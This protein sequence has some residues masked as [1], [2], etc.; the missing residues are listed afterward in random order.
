MEI[1]AQPT[2]GHCLLVHRFEYFAIIG[3]TVASIAIWIAVS[4]FQQ[5]RESEAI[6]AVHAANVGLAHTLG[7]Q[8]IQVLH[9]T[10]LQTAFLAEDVVRDG[11]R[12]VNTAKYFDRIHADLPYIRRISILDAGGNIISSSA[13]FH[14][15]SRANKKYFA[16]HR[17]D[18]TKAVFIGKPMPDRTL[19]AWQIPI[20]RR[21]NDA[22]GRFVGVVI[23]A[24]DPAYFSKQFTKAALG[25]TSRLS[26]IDADGIVLASANSQGMEIGSDVSRMPGYKFGQANA[27][28]FFIGEGNSIGA[29][30]IVAYDQLSPYSMTLHVATSLDEA[31]A[32]VHHEVTAVYLIATVITLLL[33]A[34]SFTIARQ[35]DGQ[36]RATREASAA[37]ER[38][39]RLLDENRSL[40]ANLE[41]RV[42]ERTAELEAANRELNSFSYTIAHDLRAPVRAMGGYSSLVLEKS[43]ALLDATA[44]QYL[45]RVVAGSKRMGQLIDDLLNMARLSRQE[46][47]RTDIDLTELAGAVAGALEAA[48]PQREVEVKIQPA[49]HT[50]GDAGLLR[51]VLENLIGNAWKFTGKRAGAKI[52]IEAVQ[53]DGKTTF[54]VRDNGTGFDMQYANKLFAPFQ[55]LHHTNE[56]EGTGIGLVTVKKI[57]ERHGGKIWIE[58][59]IGVG[60]TIFFTIGDAV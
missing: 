9:E 37:R 51:V 34:A 32:P 50:N 4:Q 49:M 17:E 10:D 1:R 41:R 55:R 14:D 54:R 44:V 3:G 53:Q 5:H 42:A 16:V 12:S 30:R 59:A 47:Q 7:E 29:P 36:R 58:S 11:A 46:V 35:F 24:L 22:A 40:N 23:M 57:I 38:A 19:G 26:L 18:V 27:A 31:I 48:H 6:A 33:M 56:F 45:Q 28:G 8:V 2:F 52:E 20:S 43:Q 39:E 21:L 15:E 25:E 60:T 13:P